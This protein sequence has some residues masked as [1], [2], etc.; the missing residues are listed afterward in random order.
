MRP[1]SLGAGSEIEH[2]LRTAFCTVCAPQF[3]PGAAI[4]GREQENVVHRPEGGAARDAANLCDPPGPLDGAVGTPDADVR[5]TLL[6]GAAAIAPVDDHHALVEA[7][8]EV[9]CAR[10]L[11]PDPATAMALAQAAAYEKEWS[12]LDGALAD[13]DPDA[14]ISGAEP[15]LGILA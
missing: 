11:S 14:H 15:L 4:F 9:V 5:A 1:A 6:E 2:R 8:A 3:N 12:L 13:I 10:Q 7:G